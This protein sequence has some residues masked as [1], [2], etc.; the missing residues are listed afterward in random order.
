MSFFFLISHASQSPVLSHAGAGELPG[1]LKQDNPLAPNGVQ[2]SLPCS[3]VGVNSVSAEF[4]LFVFST[5][6]A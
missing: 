6:F 3:L 5:E 2:S 1:T 4:F